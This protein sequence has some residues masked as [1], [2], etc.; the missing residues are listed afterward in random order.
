MNYQDRWPDMRMK[1]L[2]MLQSIVVRMNSCSQQCKVAALAVLTA[3]I[4]LATATGD[5]DAALIAIP[6]LLLFSAL[7]AHYLRLERSVRARFDKVRSTELLEAPDFDLGPI[8]D[9][10]IWSA[11]T[12]PSVIMFYFGAISVAGAAFVFIVETVA[13]SI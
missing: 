12:S 7:D 3:V 4:G 13:P 6:V 9:Q 11:I 5:K 8:R 10:S 1:H 2:E